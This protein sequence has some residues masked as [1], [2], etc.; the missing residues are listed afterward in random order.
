MHLILTPYLNEGIMSDL[1]THLADGSRSRSAW[2]F[3]GTG[4]LGSLVAAQ[5]W[6][7]SSTEVCVL[8]RSGRT[9]S[10]GHQFAE[11]SVS[12]ARCDASSSDE[13]NSLVEASRRSASCMPGKCQHYIVQPYAESFW[14]RIKRDHNCLLADLCVEHSCKIYMVCNGDLPMIYVCCKSQ[15]KGIMYFVY[16]LNTVIDICVIC[17]GR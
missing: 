17:G 13:W 3:G 12:I 16:Y 1:Y 5:Y 6:Q 7:E 11:N 15:G 9:L 8:G 4:A 10:Q 2:I 14:Q